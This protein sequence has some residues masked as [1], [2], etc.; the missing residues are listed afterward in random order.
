MLNTKSLLSEIDFG[1]NNARIH[2]RFPKREFTLDELGR[3]WR[4][5][6][7]IW[8]WDEGDKTYQADLLT[9]RKVIGGLYNRAVFAESTIID[10]LR[11]EARR[12]AEVELREDIKAEVHREFLSSLEERQKLEGEATRKEFVR[13]GKLMISKLR[14]RA[15]GSQILASYVDDDRRNHYTHTYLI[16]D[17]LGVSD[18]PERVFYKNELKWLNRRRSALLECLHALDSAMASYRPK[19]KVTKPRYRVK[20]VCVPMAQAA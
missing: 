14:F 1:E 20:A 10:E 15:D 16:S 12:R 19:G 7:E 5:P 13:L 17:I 3:G 8:G 11:V 6:R 2:A 9:A 18:L 4:N